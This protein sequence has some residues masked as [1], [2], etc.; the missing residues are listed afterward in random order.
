MKKIGL[1]VIAMFVGIA[2]TNAQYTTLLWEDFNDTII[3]TDPAWDPAVYP[4]SILNDTNWY[5]YDEDQ[6]PDQSTNQDRPGNWF[7]VDGGFT[8]PDTLDVC[9]YSNSWTLDINPVSNWLVLPA[10]QITDGASARLLW[11]SAPRQTPYYLDGFEILVSTTTNDLVEFTNVIYTA[12]EYESGAPSGGN[13]YANYTFSSGWVHGADGLFVECD[14]CTVP[15]SLARQVGVQRPDSVSLAAFDNQKIYIAFHHTSVDD[16]LIS[17][18]DIMVKEIVDPTFS[19]EDNGT[20]NGSIYPNPAT[21]FTM[22]N[23]DITQYHHLNIQLFNSNGQVIYAAPLT[24]NN[25][26]L[27]LQSVAAGVY[28]VQVTADEGSMTKKLVVSK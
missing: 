10:I 2:V 17:L 14:T 3:G 15:T 9:L 6:L 18:D 22:I 25:Y 12:A 7:L 24:E 19:I 8:F 4:N 21:D 28:I 1:L 27:D 26:R 13:N 5:S 16:N 20:L 11:K 23:F